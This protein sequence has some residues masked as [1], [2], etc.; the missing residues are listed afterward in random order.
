MDGALLNLAQAAQRVADF[1]R[2]A[3]EG[4]LPDPAALHRAMADYDRRAA[5]YRGDITPGDFV[6]QDA[7]RF[8][9]PQMIEAMERIA[10]LLDREFAPPKRR[11]GE[12]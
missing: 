12:D 8:E 4:S 10:Q 2:E 5:G 1:A 11:F 6:R 3:V 9:D 7:E